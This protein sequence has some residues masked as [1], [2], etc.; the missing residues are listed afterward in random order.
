[1]RGSFRSAIMGGGSMFRLAYNTNGLAPL[2]SVIT[3]YRVYGRTVGRNASLPAD[4]NTSN[5]AWAALTPAKVALGSPATVQ[6]TCATD[7]DAYLGLTLVFDGATP[8]ETKAVSASPRKVQ[9]GPTLAQPGD[10]DFRV[11]PRNPRSQRDR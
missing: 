1:M 8:F 7:C 11:I 3:G 4:R 6:V 9:A 10:P 5:P 2:S